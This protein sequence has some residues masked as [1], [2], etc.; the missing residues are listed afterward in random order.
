MAHN[1]LQPTGIQWIW[2][3][4]SKYVN[5]EWLSVEGWAGALVKLMEATH[6][7]QQYT[8]GEQHPSVFRSPTATVELSNWSEIFMICS[9]I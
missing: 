7:P 9:Q 2:G 3:W 8:N 4:Y 1:W 5:F 6:Q